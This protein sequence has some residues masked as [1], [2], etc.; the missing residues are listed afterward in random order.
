MSYEDFVMRTVRN[1]RTP[2]TLD[3]AFHTATYAS[4]ITK[5]EQP[6]KRDLKHIASFVL[7]ATVIVV[8]SYVLNTMFDLFLESIR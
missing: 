1:Q 3:E 7:V 4:A 2:R 8:S 5:F 6:Y